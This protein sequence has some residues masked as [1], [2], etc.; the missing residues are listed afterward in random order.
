MSDFETDQATAA[1]FPWTT[2]TS[3]TLPYLSPGNGT[4][5]K[6]SPYVWVT[7]MSKIIAGEAFCEWSLWSRN[8]QRR[9][10]SKS[11]LFTGPGRLQKQPIVEAT[12]A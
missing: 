9:F 11:L 3:D 12:A 2:E 8:L 7:W 5:P 6:A 1:D 10:H 4:Q